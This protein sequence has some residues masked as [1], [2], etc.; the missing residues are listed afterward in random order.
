MRWDTETGESGSSWATLYTVAYNKREIQISS[1]LKVE[2]DVGTDIV[3]CPLAP[4]STHT[5]R[6]RGRERVLS[7]EAEGVSYP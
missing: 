5:K 2:G 3:G 4:M 1:D 6:E 7:W